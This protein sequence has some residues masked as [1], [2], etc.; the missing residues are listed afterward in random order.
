MKDVVVETV[1]ELLRV[2]LLAVIPVAVDGL[3]TGEVNW[4][5]I[6]IAGAIAALRALDKFLHLWG[7]EKENDGLAKGLVRF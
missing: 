5:L 6:L 1:K 4:R 3:S 7:Q 2:A